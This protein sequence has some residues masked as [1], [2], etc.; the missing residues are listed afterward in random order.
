MPLKAGSINEPKP[1]T[2]DEQSM[3]QAMAQAFRDQWPLVM[4]DQKLPEDT[5]Q[6]QLLFVEIAQGIITHL[7][8]NP[9]AFRVLVTQSNGAGAAGTVVAIEAAT[10]DGEL[11]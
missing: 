4:G 6:T 9:E 3:A 8:Q 7:V 11:I 10:E 5:P 2:P 1:P